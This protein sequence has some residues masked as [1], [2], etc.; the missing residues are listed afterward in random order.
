MLHRYRNVF[1]RFEGKSPEYETIQSGYSGATIIRIR[2]REQSWCLRGWPT[3]TLPEDRIRELHRWLTFLAENGLPVAVPVPDDTGD[4]LPAHQEQFWQLEPWLPGEADLEEDSS[5]PRLNAAMETLATLHLISEQYRC[6]D[7]ARDWFSQWN[8]RSETIQQ[9][10][11]L[12]QNWNASEFGA[13][14]RALHDVSYEF[15]AH[16]EAGLAILA[17]TQRVRAR[18]LGDLDALSNVVVRQFP[19]LRDVWHAHILMDDSQVTG[20][21]DPS[22]ART[23]TVSCD[24]SRLLGGLPLDTGE[25]TA[26]IASY[27]SVRALSSAERSLLI[28]LTTSGLVLS[29]LTWVSRLCDHSFQDPA[30][31]VLDRM[32]TLRARMTTFDALSRSFTG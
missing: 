15:A 11:S 14:A 31:H 6:R 29:G 8:G 24:L 10:I 23:E 7:S 22:H 19:C 30:R 27:S 4:T 9:R 16:R 13:V 2:I 18:L 21:I 17:H 1:L 5:P 25:W 3:V 12:L 20:I 26:A 32:N 28:P